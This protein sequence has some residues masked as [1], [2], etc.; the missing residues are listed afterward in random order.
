MP[1]ARYTVTI[2]LGQGKRRRIHGVEGPTEVDAR[3]RIRSLQ[4][5]GIYP[6]G[7]LT[8]S[9]QKEKSCTK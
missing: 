5:R 4:D 3:K 1:L 2:N 9:E 8:L 7:R 6:E